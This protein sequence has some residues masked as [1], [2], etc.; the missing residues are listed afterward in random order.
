VG[1]IESQYIADLI[2]LAQKNPA[3]EILLKIGQ[4]DRAIE[5]LFEQQTHSGFDEEYNLNELGVFLGDLIESFQSERLLL[6]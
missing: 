5:G 1:Y 2:N 4:V 6:D 3:G